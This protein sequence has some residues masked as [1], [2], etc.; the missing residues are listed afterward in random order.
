MSKALTNVDIER[1]MKGQPNFKG[2]FAIDILPKKAEGSGIVNYDKI[3]GTGTHWICWFNDNKSKFV[4]TF[5]SMGLPPPEKIVNF[6]RTSGKQIQYNDIQYQPKDS[7]NCGWYC[8]HYIKERNKGRSPYDI[9]YSFKQVPS[10]FNERLIVGGGLTMSEEN[11]LRDIYYNPKTGYSGVNDLVRKSGLT[12]SK[13]KEFL[14]QQDVYTRHKNIR[15]RFPTRRVIVGGIDDQFQ[16]DLV[17]MIPYAKE[18][19]NY[20]YMLT[21][22]DCFSKYAWAIPMKNK[23]ADETI[24]AFDIIFSEAAAPGCARKPRK[25]QTDHGK[26]YTNKK[27]QYYLNKL[28]I[29]WFATNSEF[30]ASIVERFNRTLKSLMWKYFTDMGN[31]R[32]I[33]VIPDLVSNY[34]HR[35]H[36]SIGMTPA[37]ASKKENESVVRMNLYPGDISNQSST[38]PKFKVG[39]LVRI[40]KYKTPFSKSYE[41]NFTNETFKISKVLNTVP[42]T[43]KVKDFNGEEILGSFYAEQLSRFNN[44]DNEWEIEEILKRRTRNGRKEVLIKWKGYS[45]DFNSWIPSSAVNSYADNI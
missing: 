8:V 24:K 25:L 17:E 40:S 1:I 39:D 43:Y 44:V 10:S 41:G 33:D 35:K 27:L 32:W 3:G 6:L 5:N 36:S 29:H 34:N 28:N 9:L 14:E 18:N 13:V 26:E 7:I 19:N 30:K 37:E 20:K 2:V 16:A 15:K 38:Q 22:I 42:P 11:K 12:K 45:G 31:K 21:C 23:T 4:E